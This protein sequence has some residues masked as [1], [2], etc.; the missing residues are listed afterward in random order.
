MKLKSLL[1]TLGLKPSVRKYGTER[2]DFHLDREGP[3][4]F[5]RWLHPK[6]RF[7]AFGQ[8]YVDRL[9]QY[10]RPG[11]AVLDIGAHCGDFTVP[12]A[13]AAGPSGIVFAWEP[14]PYV[15]DVLAKNAALNTHA[16]RIVPVRREFGGDQSLDAWSR[17]RAQSASD[18]SGEL[19]GSRVSRMDQQDSLC[20]SGHGRFRSRS[21][22]IFGNDAC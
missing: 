7:V 9:R 12:L 2:L 13:L 15:F 14:N 4:A 18:A 5:E 21:A 20:Q 22:T 3:I 6:D 1:W 19:D 8:T 16:T 11:D 17:I 10:V